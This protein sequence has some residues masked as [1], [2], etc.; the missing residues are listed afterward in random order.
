[1]LEVTTD[2]SGRITGTL[3]F[4][5]GVA[6]TI[7]GSVTPAAGKLPEGI[8]LSGEG[9]SALDNL[10]GFFLAGSDHVVGTVVA[11]RNDLGKQPAGTSGPF[12]T[13]P[14]GLEAPLRAIGR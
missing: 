5:P 9:P 8:E 11:I 2:Q 14:L 10:R 4:G 13:F 3:T 7:T 6:R 1:V 12:V